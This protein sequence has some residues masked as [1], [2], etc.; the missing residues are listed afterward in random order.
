MVAPLP[1][2]MTAGAYSA[3]DV[4]VQMCRTILYIP[5]EGFHL[6]NHWSFHRSQVVSVLLR[7]PD[8]D[9][10]QLIVIFVDKG[11]MQQGVH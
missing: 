9:S 7:S 6:P 10:G 11:A 1:L 8:S 2:T 3:G 4:C 5:T